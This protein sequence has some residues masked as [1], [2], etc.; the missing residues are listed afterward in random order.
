MVYVCTLLGGGHTCIQHY[1]SIE[2]TL[3][4]SESDGAT[5]EDV[6]TEVAWGKAFPSGHFGF[7]FYFYA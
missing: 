6:L 2:Y 3:Q 4:R 1:R 5:G 7:T